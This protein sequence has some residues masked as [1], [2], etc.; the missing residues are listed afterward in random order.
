MAEK[1][2]VWCIL[3]ERRDALDWHDIE[4]LQKTV[5]DLG[6][7]NSAIKDW[8]KNQKDIVIFHDSRGRSFIGAS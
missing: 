7:G 8:R 6:A 3:E 5:E 1:K 4:S 2:R